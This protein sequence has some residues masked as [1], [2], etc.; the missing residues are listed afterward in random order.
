MFAQRSLGH[1]EAQILVK[2]TKAIHDILLK[3]GAAVR[4]TDGPF[5][6]FGAIVEEMNYWKGKVRVAVQIL[7]RA[8][9]VELDFSQVEEV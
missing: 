9:P 6:N 4:V 5:A 7:D 2:V 8:V 1:L 3:P